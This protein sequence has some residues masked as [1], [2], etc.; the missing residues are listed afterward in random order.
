[1]IQKR[2]YKE[3]LDFFIRRSGLSKAE[4][5][6][7]TGISPARL[8]QATKLSKFFLNDKGLEDVA[9]VVDITDF[10][11]FLIIYQ[12]AIERY[13]KKRGKRI[14]LK[15]KKFFPLIEKL[16]TDSLEKKDIDEFRPD[17]LDGIEL[18]MHDIEHDEARETLQSAF[19]FIKRRYI[20]IDK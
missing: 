20:N 3:Y 19:D 10:E 1:M 8:T 12:H 2:Y 15:V 16:L 18:L 13:N 4:V 5:S 6:R 9:E 17:P 14:L 11:L 7:R